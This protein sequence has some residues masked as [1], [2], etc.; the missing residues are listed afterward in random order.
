MRKPQTYLKEKFLRTATGVG[1]SWDLFKNTVYWI[2]KGKIA[3]KNVINQMVEIGVGS[4]PVVFLTSI[5]TG[6][7]LAL[8]TGLASRRILGEPVYVGTVVAFSMLKELG[9]V[10]SSVILSGRVGASI[11]AEL[12]TMK[13]TEQIEAL[14]TLGTNPV[15]YL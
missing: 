15:R 2:V 10:L 14:F 3:F 4:F 13:V 1:L 11:A 7:V 9:P 6:M 12:G 5:F 8:Q